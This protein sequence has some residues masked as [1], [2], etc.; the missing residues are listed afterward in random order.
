MLHAS[1][2]VDVVCVCVCHV[3]SGHVGAP[4][5]CNVVKLVDVEEMNYFAS[6]GEGEVRKPRPPVRTA[7]TTP[8]LQWLLMLA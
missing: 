1:V 3:L 5:P 6:N 7:P 2:V 8:S 4:I